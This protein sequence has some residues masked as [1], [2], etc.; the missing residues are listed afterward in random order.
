MGGILFKLTEKIIKKGEAFKRKKMKKL[1]KLRAKCSCLLAMFLA[2]AMFAPT[3]SAAAEDITEAIGII[4]EQVAETET[5]TEANTESDELLTVPA[6]PT[7]MSIKLISA[8]SAKLSWDA[9]TG[10]EEYTVYR[11]IN[12]AEWKAIKKVTDTTTTTYN[13]A[14]GN[15]YSYKVCVTKINSIAVA[16]EFSEE[17]SIELTVPGTPSGLA[18]SDKADTSLKLS[19]ATVADADGYVVYRKSIDSDWSRIKYVSSTSVYDEGLS[20]EKAYQYKVSAY[21]NIGGYKYEG[22]CSSAIVTYPAKTIVPQNFKMSLISPLDVRLEWDAVPGA[23]EYTIVATRYL[24]PGFSGFGFD[25]EFVTSETSYVFEYLTSEYQYD[26]TVYVSK[27]DSTTVVGESAEKQYLDWECIYSSGEFTV[28]ENTD[29]NSVL[30]EWPEIEGV[31][32]Y[33][34]YVKN[35]DGKW[36]EDRVLSET[37]CTYSDLVDDKFYEYKVAAYITYH[38]FRVPGQFAYG[39]VKIG[40]KPIKRALLVGQTAYSPVLKGPDNDVDAMEA[41]LLAQGY[42]LVVKTMNLSSIGVEVKIDETFGPASENDISLFYYSGHGVTSSGDYQGALACVSGTMRTE[43]LAAH[44]ED[45]AGKVIVILDSCGSGAAITPKGT[46]GTA[47]FDIEAF[48][49]SFVSAFEEY[50]N[51]ASKQGEMLTDKFIVMTAASM[52]EY[53]WETGVSSTKSGGIFTYNVACAVGMDYSAGTFATT[54]PADYNS[55]NKITWAELYYYVYYEVLEE[56]FYDT[57][58]GWI[59]QHVKAYPEDSSFVFFEK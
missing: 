29:G 13:L 54:M 50:N 26:Y 47:E 36:V 45:V 12:G 19:W 52:G 18:A 33:V 37:S 31:E 41:I 25:E 42:D 6:P 40:G 3:V 44:L 34:I 32:G 56:D 20:V 35:A 58:L 49:E 16:G 1:K 17:A 14:N 57:D 2:F 27:F 22:S 23:E 15:T 43:T 9:V 55:D 46:D 10:A 5:E 38:G 30:L 11:S 7:N 21:K 51:V 28:V 48:N 8:T 59:K 4:A 24:M 39:C 53:S